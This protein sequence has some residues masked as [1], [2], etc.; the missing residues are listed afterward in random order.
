VSAESTKDSVL[1]AKELIRDGD[2]AYKIGLYDFAGTIYYPAAQSV[3]PRDCT[4]LIF[5]TFLG[6][7]NSY[8]ESWAKEAHYP[9]VYQSALR[10]YNKAIDI[11]QESYT[12]H[13]KRGI[14][15]FKNSEYTEAM[16]DFNKLINLQ[17]SNPLGYHLRSLTKYGLYDYYGAISDID[18][19][20]DYDSSIEEYYYIRGDSRRNLANHESSIEDFNRAINLNPKYGYAYLGRGLA[21]ISIGLKKRGC[22]DLS[23]AG[24][25]GIEAAYK[26]IKLR[27]GSSNFINDFVK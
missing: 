20:I 18:I 3:T 23:K 7:A 10:F 14:L 19:A 6:I 15:F 9:D 16:K 5:E 1:L 17:P 24:E 4:N 26:E 25:L 13:R 27:C 12:A 21:R 22:Q 2:S 11:K 8:A